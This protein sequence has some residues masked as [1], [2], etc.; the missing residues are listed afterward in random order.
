M[1]YLSISDFKYGM[2]RRRE[3]VAG[4]PGSLWTLENAHIT[5][6]GDMERCRKV[7]P[8]SAFRIPEGEDIAPLAGVASQERALTALEL[9]L[10]I[11][12]PRFHVVVVGASGTGQINAVFP[13]TPVSGDA[14][15]RAQASSAE[16]Y[17]NIQQ[18]L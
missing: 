9:G 16:G 4:T 5:R 15:P 3:R 14:I 1:A 8:A 6:G 7:V 10:D 13:V 17:T 11:Q 18:R 12:Q 2:D